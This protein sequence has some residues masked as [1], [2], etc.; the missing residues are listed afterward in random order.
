MNFIK[1]ILLILAVILTFPQSILSAT[2]VKKETIQRTI[3]SIRSFEYGQSTQPQRELERFINETNGDPDL[4]GAI[5]RQILDALVSVETTLA[6]KTFFCQKLATIG[7]DAS[8]PVLS[9][10]LLKAETV[11]MACYA[12]K[13][14][15]SSGADRYLREALERIQGKEKVPVIRILGERRDMESVD[16]LADSLKA[17]GE[18]IAPAAAAALGSIGTSG[19]VALLTQCRKANRGELKF[20]LA[21]ALLECAINIV[22][23]G[24]IDE[25]AVLLHELDNKNE[26]TVIQQGARHNLLAIG[27][28]DIDFEAIEPVALFDGMTF[29][30]WEGNLD[31]FRIDEGAINAGNLDKRIPLNEFICTNREYAHFELRLK[32]K[33]SATEANAGIQIRSRRFPGSREMCGYQADMGQHYWGCLYDESRRNKVLAEANRDALAKALRPADWNAYAIRC[34]GRRIQL[35]INGHQT[36]DYLEPD[37]T[38]EQAGLIGLQIHA[39]PPAMAGYKDIEIRVFDEA[40]IR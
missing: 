4:R 39:G 40:S 28:L 2:T 36:V 38:I 10:M 19:C 17:G 21:D 9:T 37:E 13:T 8:L 20:A 32:C 24:N 16:V 26:P 14:N 30:G 11:E 22:K 18:E 33:L 34:V 35:W 25:A 15:P 27:R 29:D 5:E 31:W 12:L 6:A 3:D 7:S 1:Q 23:S